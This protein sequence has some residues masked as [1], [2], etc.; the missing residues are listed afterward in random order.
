MSNQFI[1]ATTHS[2]LDKLIISARCSAPI[3]THTR[4]YSLV[5]IILAGLT[6]CA[7]P[8]GKVERWGISGVEV[9]EISG[10]VVDV[11]CEVSGNCVEQCGSGTRQI[12]IKTQQG[13][14]LVAK[15][16][17]R[18]S[19]GAE[20]LWPFCS[21]QLVVNGQFT[22]TGPTRFFQVQNVRMPDGGWMSTSR[23]LEVWAEKNGKPVNAAN[24][25][26]LEDQRVETIL[27]RDGLLGL[28]PNVNP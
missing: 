3:R 17:N 15:D 11:L 18:Y 20:E 26:Y 28:G 4:L 12:G 14:V 24:K 19:G 23:F 6:A 25:W 7:T 22:E 8:A 5:L 2:R 10:E 9:A 27:K 13:M 16:L 1:E 21:Q